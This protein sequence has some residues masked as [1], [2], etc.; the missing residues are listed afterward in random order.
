MG[1]FPS[2]NYDV[3]V[4]QTS[5]VDVEPASEPPLLPFSPQAR[6]SKKRKNPIAADIALL[7]IKN[8]FTVANRKGIKIMALTAACHFGSF[9]YPL[10]GRR[11]CAVRSHGLYHFGGIYIVNIVNKF[12]TQNDKRS[13][14][15]YL[16]MFGVKS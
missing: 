10:W 1:C 5:R 6:I 2:F 12:Y 3:S 15:Y 8:P 11:L 16:F 9:L 7:S 13:S 14:Y 4:N